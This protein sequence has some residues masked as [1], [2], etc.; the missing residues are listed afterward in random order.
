MKHHLISARRRDLE[1]IN[2]KILDFAVHVEQWAKK[3][4]ENEKKGM[5]EDLARELKKNYG[6][7]DTSCNGRARNNPQKVW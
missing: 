5:Y 7:G 4:E 1:I 6:D 3:K 2:K